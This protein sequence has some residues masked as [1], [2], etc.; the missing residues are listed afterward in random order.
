MKTEKILSKF[1]LAT[2]VAQVAFYSFKFVR[3]FKKK[4]NFKKVKS[5]LK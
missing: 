4:D 1:F 3:K 5:K 2:T